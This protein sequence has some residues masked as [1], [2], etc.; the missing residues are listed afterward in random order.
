MKFMFSGALLRFAGFAKEIEISEP[1]LELAL[2]ALL[3]Q[4]PT[5]RPVLL[6][7]E[8]NL[9]RSHQMFVNGESVES[10]YYSDS[11]ARSEL[12]LGHEDSVFFLTAIAGG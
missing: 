7:G 10:R 11:Q 2:K 4:R 5:L 8:G 3:A 9:R 1:N 12:A 6:H